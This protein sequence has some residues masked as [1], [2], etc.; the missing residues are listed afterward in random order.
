MLPPQQTK[1]TSAAMLRGMIALE[2]KLAWA[3]VS[4]VTV[5]AGTYILVLGDPGFGSLRDLLACLLWGLGLP[6]GT[7]LASTTTASIASTYNVAR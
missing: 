3:F 1:G 6:A 5:L 2:G 7:L 4:V